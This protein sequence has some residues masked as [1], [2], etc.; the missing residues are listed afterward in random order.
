MSLLPLVRLRT[1]SAP[2]EGP[3]RVILRG[4]DVP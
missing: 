2:G 1:E 3:P 4:A